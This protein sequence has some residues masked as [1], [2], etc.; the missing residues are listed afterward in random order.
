MKTE[1]LVS[2]STIPSKIYSNQQPFTER[3]TGTIHRHLPF[4]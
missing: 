1:I 3:K 4:W 2:E